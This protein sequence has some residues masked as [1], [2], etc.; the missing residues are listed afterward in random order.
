[1]TGLEQDSAGSRPRGKQDEG[2]VSSRLE[3]GDG[4]HDSGLAAQT[5]RTCF[6]GT[7]TIASPKSYSAK[8]FLAVH[9]VPREKRS[10]SNEWVTQ[11]SFPFAGGPSRFPSPS[12]VRPETWKFTVNFSSQ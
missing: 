6:P 11:V 8:E 5:S 3:V 7:R 4:T 2:R 9:T 10:R 12:G 1:M